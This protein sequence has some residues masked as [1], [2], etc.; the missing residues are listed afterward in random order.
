[1]IIMYSESQLVYLT[2]SMDFSANLGS[3]FGVWKARWWPLSPI[4]Q[5]LLT[6]VILSTLTWLTV[7]PQ[8][9][10]NDSHTHFSVRAQAHWIITCWGAS[11]TGQLQPGEASLGL[12]GIEMHPELMSTTLQLIYL[13]SWSF[14]DHRIG[15]QLLR[16]NIAYILWGCLSNRL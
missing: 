10:T 9:Q 6:V 15:K 3:Q 13:E 8:Q 14:L 1:M 11:G 5:H 4:H 16:A 12:C 2:E 7:C